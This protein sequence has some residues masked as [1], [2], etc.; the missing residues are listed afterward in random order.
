MAERKLH[1]AKVAILGSGPAGWTAA[2]YAARANLGPLVISGPQPGGQLTTTTEVD[3]WPADVDGVQ[4]PE[5]MERF[6]AHAKRFDTR[7]EIDAIESADL[8]RRPFRLRGAEADYEC[9]ALIVATGAKAKWLGIES[10]ARYSGRGVS[11][12][13]TCDGFFH[14]G[15]PVAVVGGGSA[16]V[17]EALYL[18]GIASKVTLIHRR[19]SFRAE[20][21]LVDR[22]MGL[23]ASGKVELRLESVLQEALG[24]ES[25]LTGAR[26]AP[27]GGGPAEDIPVSGLFVAIGHE[28]NTAL[29]AGQLALREGGYLATRG[30]AAGFA[31]ATSVEG[32]FAAGDVQDSVYRQ[33]ATSAGSGCMAALDAQRFLAEKAPR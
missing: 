7:H 17:E 1:K 13:A 3:N 14:R 16:A 21:I 20:P 24:D 9:D 15:K 25:G 8:S 23:V 10:E 12:C 31:T 22:L 6:E 19:S 11:A 28:P 26:V 29:F 4:G 32:V 2:L 18:A 30:G 33:A 5:L 27:A